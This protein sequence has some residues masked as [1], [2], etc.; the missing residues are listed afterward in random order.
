MIKYNYIV[1][2]RYADRQATNLRIKAPTAARALYLA[3]KKNKNYILL[4]DFT[5][6]RITK[7]SKIL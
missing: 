7:Q 1:H 3:L 2:F 4:G 6:I 5:N